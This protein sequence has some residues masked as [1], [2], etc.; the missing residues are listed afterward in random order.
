MGLDIK[1]VSRVYTKLVESVSV[2]AL[3]NHIR[4]RT[5]KGSVYYTEAFR[6]YCS[7]RRFGK[8]HT[9]NYRKTLV[10][11]RTKNHINGI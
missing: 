9:V 4:A 11:R 6:G 10:D 2:E 5:R 7:L 1:V 3:M 8:H